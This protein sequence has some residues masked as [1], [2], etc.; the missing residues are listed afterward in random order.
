MHNILL[1]K[2][3]GFYT[4]S[5]FFDLSKA[6][7]TVDHA[8]LI[9]KLK[10]CYGIR[11]TPLCLLNNYLSNQLRYTCINST[12]SSLEFITCG[13]PQGSVLGPLL[14]SLYVN[15][16]PLDSSFKIALFADDTLL[17]MT[18]YDL[19]KLQ[20][21]VNQ[22]LA[23]IENW[24]RYNKLSLNYNKTT[25][26]IFL[27]RSCPRIETAQIDFKTTIEAAMDKTASLLTQENKAKKQLSNCSSD[28]IVHKNF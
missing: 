9:N 14:F 7:D 1:N 6:F 23:L 25:Y 18:G 16:M 13:V 26:R 10:N 17:M 8:L 11:G 28:W 27:N 22:N 5:I 19:N 15:D 21:Q 4:C 12:I 2:D 3:K 20:Q 24:L